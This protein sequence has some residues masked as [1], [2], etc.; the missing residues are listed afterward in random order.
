MIEEELPEVNHVP[1]LGGQAAQLVRGEI[2][3][4]EMSEFG[5]VWREACQV[6]VI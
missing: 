5:D 2:Q 4:G 3:V 1:N 6:I